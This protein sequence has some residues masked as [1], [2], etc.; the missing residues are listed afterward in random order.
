MALK[1]QR[2]VVNKSHN[3]QCNVIQLFFSHSFLPKRTALLYLFTF[4]VSSSQRSLPVIMSVT[5]T[6]CSHRQMALCF[7][8]Q[9]MGGFADDFLEL[10]AANVQI[11]FRKI[12]V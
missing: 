9:E 2:D 10:L 1:Q 8:L 5:L 11:I 12:H 4:N 7:F 6:L 3:A